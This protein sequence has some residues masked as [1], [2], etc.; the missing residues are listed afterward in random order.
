MS[1]TLWPLT[2]RVGKAGQ[3]ETSQKTCLHG[4]EWDTCGITGGDRT[5]SDGY[6]GR[7]GL[8]CRAAR[9]DSSLLSFSTFRTAEKVD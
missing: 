4:S 1:A 9:Y 5:T 8:L 7:C 6:N 3:T 2:R